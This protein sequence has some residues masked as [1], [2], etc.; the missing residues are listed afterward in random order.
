MQQYDDVAMENK[1]ELDQLEP[2][3]LTG[4][5]DSS[6][7]AGDLSIHAIQIFDVSCSNANQVRLTSSIA[8]SGVTVQS[9]L[10]GDLS[11]NVPGSCVKPQGG[12]QCQLRPLFGSTDHG[13]PAYLFFPRLLSHT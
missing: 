9:A 2:D 13:R 6:A 7:N 5:L 12:S 1:V 11:L 10:V 8:A 4:P 3:E